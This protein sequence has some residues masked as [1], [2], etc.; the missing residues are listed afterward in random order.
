[1]NSFLKLFTSDNI[2]RLVKHFYQPLQ[3]LFLS[4]LP[5]PTR[6]TSWGPPS[7]TLSETPF[8]TLS[9]ILLEIRL[10]KTT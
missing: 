9:E 10:D 4:R 5:E 3:F 8:K 2:T 6:K 7:K 1:M